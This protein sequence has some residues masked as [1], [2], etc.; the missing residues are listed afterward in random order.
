[1]I[2]IRSFSTFIREETLDSSGQIVCSPLSNVRTSKSAVG[3]LNM[4]TASLKLNLGEI[5]RVNSESPPD[6][7][8]RSYRPSMGWKCVEKLSKM[9]GKSRRLYNWYRKCLN[10]E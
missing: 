1:M 5:T 6:S 2:E 3:M 4:W 10:S 9:E 7:P 8:T